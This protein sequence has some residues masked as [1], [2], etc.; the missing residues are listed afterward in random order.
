MRHNYKDGWKLTRMDVTSLSPSRCCHS[1][2]FILFLFFWH[3]LYV[4]VVQLDGNAISLTIVKSFYIQK[5]TPTKS[6]KTKNLL[7]EIKMPL[8]VYRFIHCVP[9]DEYK[10]WKAQVDNGSKRG[11]ERLDIL[12]RTLLLRRTKD[13]S[14]GLYRKT[15]GNRPRLFKLAS[16][17]RHF[18]G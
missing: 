10:L 5:G 11:R 9:F 6:A 18:T 7:N 1:E 2:F 12:T 8:P 4:V 17:S 15:T 3:L 16:R 13:R 14:T